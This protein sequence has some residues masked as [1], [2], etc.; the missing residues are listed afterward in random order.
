MVGKII[1]HYKITAKLGEGGMGVVYKAEDTQLKR[2]VALKFLAAHLLKDEEARKRFHREAQA[3]AAVHHPNVCP[4]YE[5]AEVDGKTFISMAFIEGESLDK[6][7]E[8]GPLKIAEALGIAQQIA[9]GLEAAHEKGVVHRDIKPGNAIIDEKGHVTV[10]DFGLALLTEGSKLTKLDTTLGTVAY[11]SPEQAQGVKVDHRTDI[12]ALGCVLYEMVRGERPFQGVYDQ[13]L[14]YEICN[15]EP[16]PLTAVR[17]GVPMELELL[18]NKCLAKEADRRYQSTAELVVDLETLSGKL[19][20]GKSAILRARE[21]TA[22]AA[23]DSPGP[24]QTH[25]MR[26][27]A[28]ALSRV[29]WWLASVVGAALLTFFLTDRREPRSEAPLLRFAFTPDEF[30]P[31][32]HG[33]AVISPDGRFI[34]YAAGKEQT[35]LWVRDLD[36]ETP[37]ELDHTEGATAPFWSPDSRFIAFRAGAELR[38]IAVEGGLPSTICALPGTAYVRGTWSPDGE[39]VVFSAGPGGPPRIFEAPARSGTAKLLFEPIR[40]PKATG[41]DYPS[42]LPLESGRRAIV[43]DVGSPNDHDLVVFDLDTGNYQVLGAG[44]QPIYSQSGHILYRTGVGKGGLWALPFSAEN[45]RPT[46]E[47]F[48]IAE[49]GTGPSVSSEGVLVYSDFR[50][51]RG[52]KQAV[53]VNRRGEKV[54]SIGQPQDDIWSLSL[55]PDGRLLATSSDEGANVDIWIHAVEGNQKTRLTFQPAMDADPIWSPSGT[56]VAYRS[57]TREGGDIRVRPADGSGDARVLVAT[58]R[59]ERQTSWSSDGKYLAYILTD[60]EN[61]NDLWYLEFKPDGAIA[62]NRPFLQT[63]A[64]EILAVFSPDGRYVAYCSNESGRQEVYVRP[65]PEG[66]GFWQ[67]STDGGCQPQW[68]GDGSEL[69]YVQGTVLMA[70]EVSTKAS[71]RRGSV[72]RLFEHPDLSRGVGAF[73]KGYDVSPDGERFVVIESTEEGRDDPPAS[74]HVVQNWFAE[75][76]DRQS[77]AR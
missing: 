23:G 71:F 62:E 65:F 1:S 8:Q 11:M 67:V 45:L 17:T 26:R 19:E 33:R 12:W 28:A 59:I 47:P 38:R 16:E 75:F 72:R 30:D 22:L 49:S 42:C 63:P 55:S 4:V 64:S 20:S 21:A 35:K 7:I 5:I 18:V 43:F 68:S 69:F 53:W 32:R 41:H 39:S 57:E 15:Q 66:G 74:V 52:R 60:S 44:V 3:A 48:P 13:A 36:G 50:I 2:P 56:E 77:A 61:N 27:P 6:R 76:Q 54:G 51:S 9:K 29:A 73:P 10:M 37:R 70:A 14:L 58:D 46:G 31:E 25:E 34:A 24:T 40:I